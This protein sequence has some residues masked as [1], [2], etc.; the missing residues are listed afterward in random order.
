MGGSAE[1]V[2]GTGEGE[3]GL[4]LSLA[5][6]AVPWNFTLLLKASAHRTVDGSS[7][8]DALWVCAL[9]RCAGSAVLRRTFN[10]LLQNWRCVCSCLLGSWSDVSLWA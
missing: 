1:D 10:F 4:R 5:A 7:S 8:C 6:Q 9:G 2:V 3:Q